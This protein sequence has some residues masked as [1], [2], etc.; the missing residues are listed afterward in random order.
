MDGHRRPRRS[1]P[2]DAPAANGRE[3]VEPRIGATSLGAEPVAGFGARWALVTERLR[4]GQRDDRLGLSTGCERL[5]K[6]APRRPLRTMG[7]R[8][9]GAACMPGSVTER[10]PSARLRV[11]AE[12]R[13]KRS[14]WSHARYLRKCTERS[15]WRVVPTRSPSRIRISRHTAQRLALGP[16]APA[17]DHVAREPGAERRAATAAPLPNRLGRAPGAQISLSCWRG[18]AG[19]GRRV[20]RPAIGPPWVD[21]ADPWPRQ[22]APVASYESRPWQRL[23]AAS[24]AC[25]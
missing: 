8:F 23:R 6:R 2:A 18:A 16:V 3:A 5:A 13:R 10:T 9:V 17:S 25:R 19:R 15:C 1:F 12:L 7:R 22:R 24:S 21:R 14:G 20:P 11:S 4:S